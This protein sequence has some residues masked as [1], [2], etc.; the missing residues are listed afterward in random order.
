[1]GDLL[2]FLLGPQ[3]IVCLTE[4]AAEW[5]RRL[6]LEY[7]IAGMQESLQARAFVDALGLLNQDVADACRRVTLMAAGLPFTLKDAP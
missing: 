3:R 7:R 6:G 2:R 4:G 1:M 5:R